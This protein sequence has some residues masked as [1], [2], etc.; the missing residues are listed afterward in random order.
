MPSARHRRTPSATLSRVALP[1]AGF[2]VTKGLST[3][4]GEAVSDWSVNAL[5][6]EV[7]VTV[8][9]LG[10]AVALVVQLRRHRYTRWA[11]W[12]TVA[13]VGVFGTMAADVTHIVLHA[14]YL[15]SFAGYGAVLAILFIA[16]RVREGT[17]DVHQVTTLPRECFYWVAVVLTFA[18]GT[19][20]GDLTAITLKLG[21][22][23]SA[24]LFA[25]AILVPALGRRLL[26]WNAVVCF[27]A[28]YTLTRPLGASL[29]DWLG[30]PVVDGG[31]GVGAGLVGILLALAMAG[32]VAVFGGQMATEVNVSTPKASSTAD[33]R[34]KGEP[35]PS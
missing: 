7:A 28:A 15:V 10:F 25:G 16:W 1:T 20:L 11:Y 22:L 30:K 35:E 17:V 18:M 23:P 6:P 5:I 21:Y 13:M 32:A 19:A 2:W 34:P 4:M 29:A 33:A 8:G 9:F 27:W 3:A 24:V 14:P 31:R 12:A 26:S